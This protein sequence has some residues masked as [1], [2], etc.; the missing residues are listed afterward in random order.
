MYEYTVYDPTTGVILRWGSVT[1][2]DDWDLQ[3][4]EGEALW[5]F[6]EIL[7]D[8]EWKIVDGEKVSL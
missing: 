8:D 7:K 6:K 4:G 2:L 1:Q 5:K 3:A